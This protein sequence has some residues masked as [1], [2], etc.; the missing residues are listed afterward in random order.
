MT[1]HGSK[2]DANDDTFASKLQSFATGGSH[3][4]PI[5]V[6]RDDLLAMPSNEVYVQHWPAPLGNRYYRNMMP[7]V[8]SVSACSTC[9]RVSLC[10]EVDSGS[11]IFLVLPH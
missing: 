7:D 3:F 8:V 10:A 4:E 6:N 11:L 9:N 5:R 1:L 2:G